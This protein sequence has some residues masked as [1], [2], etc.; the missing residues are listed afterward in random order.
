MLHMKLIWLELDLLLV[1]RAVM[2]SDSKDL[3][4]IT[5]FIIFLY[6]LFPG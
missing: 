2:L 6:K 3:L 5:L 1:F 4:R